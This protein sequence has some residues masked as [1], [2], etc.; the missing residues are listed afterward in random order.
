VPP[1]ADALTA[2]H[3]SLIFLDIRLE[4]SDAVGAIRTLEESGY[5]ASFRS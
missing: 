1:L 3:P 5:T 4:G 2:E